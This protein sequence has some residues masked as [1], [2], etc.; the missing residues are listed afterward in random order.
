M[1][2]AAPDPLLQAQQ[3]AEMYRKLPPQ[4]QSA[5]MN[6]FIGALESPDNDYTGNDL[7]HHQN[8]ATPLESDT[9]GDIGEILSDEDRALLNGDSNENEG[10]D[11]SDGEHAAPVD[12]ND[13]VDRQGDSRGF[14]PS[15]H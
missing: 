14:P 1:I 11:F 12:H 8:I 2:A 15:A 9:L 13:Q 4:E 3:M 5:V 10:G 6:A 7:D